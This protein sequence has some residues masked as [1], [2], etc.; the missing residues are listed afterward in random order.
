MHTTHNIAIAFCLN[1]AGVVIIYLMI[2]FVISKYFHEYKLYVFNEYKKAAYKILKSNIGKEEKTEIKFYNLYNSSSGADN[3]GKPLDLHRI[4]KNYWSNPEYFA[5]LL[6]LKKDNI[7]LSENFLLYR[8]RHR[9]RLRT[10][11]N[12]DTFIKKAKLYSW[13]IPFIK[14]IK[15]AH[16]KNI[17]GYYNSYELEKLFQEKSCI[18]VRFKIFLDFLT[19]FFKKKS[20]ILH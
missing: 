4:F 8:H 3:F 18:E 16:F 6:A 2:M 12:E 5:V 1:F 19:W 17:A 7:L 11:E 20:V 14:W 15:I 13:A 10:S 9:F